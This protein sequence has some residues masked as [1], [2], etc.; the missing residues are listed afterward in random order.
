MFIFQSY[1]VNIE[2]DY[3]SSIGAYLILLGAF[4]VFVFKF[5][6]KKFIHEKTD[7]TSTNNNKSLLN[8]N[9]TTEVSLGPNTNEILNKNQNKQC[10]KDFSYK[11]IFK[12]FISFKF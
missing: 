9:N 6:E 1:L 7:I 12:L 11:K 10:Q 2:K 4:L 3:L 5:I 8:E